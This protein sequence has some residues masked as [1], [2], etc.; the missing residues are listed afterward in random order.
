MNKNMKR[1][2]LNIAIAAVLLLLPACED[3]LEVEPLTKVPS[4]VFLSD[5]NGINT[6]LANLYVKMPMEDFMYNPGKFFNYHRDLG[7]NAFV[8]FGWST[9]FLTDE[10]NY[11]SGSGAGPVNDNYWA[12]GAVT[13]SGNNNISNGAYGSIRQVNQFLVDVE[14]ASIDENVRKRCISEGHFIRAY[15][16]FGLVKR[17][18][19]VPIIEVPQ[20]PGDDLFVP[21]STEKETFDFILRECDLAVEN[22]PA[23]TSVNDGVYRA[24][25]WAAYALKS[26]VALYAASVAKFSNKAPLTG[27]AVD[28][29]LVGGMTEADA[30]NYYSQC[31]SASAA[32]IDNSGKSLFRPNPATRTDAAKNFQDLFQ[33]PTGAMEEVIFMKAYIDGSTTRMQGHSYDV[34]FNPSQT[35]PSY[36]YYGRFNPTL[37]L[38]DLFEDY[39]DDG[40]GRSVPLETRTDGIEDE[41][42]ANPGT[43]LD[44]SKPYRLYNNPTEIFANKDARFFASIIT[45]G[46]VWKGKTMVI[47]GGLIRSDGTK[48]IYQNGSAVGLDGITYYTY[49][50]ASGPEYSG[51]AQLGN[52]E[53]GNFTS[54]GFNV[55]KYLRESMTTLTQFICTTPYIDFR[56][57]EIY[58]NYAEATVESG[59]GNPTLAAQYLND[60][61]RRAGHTDNIPATIDNI[62][63]ER[64]IELAFEGHRYWDLVR[65]RDSHLAFNKT[66]RK[67]LV[68][69]LDL[70]ENPPKYFFVRANNWPDNNAGGRT[71]ETK[72][73]Y[74][75]IPDVS[76]S[77][78]VQNPQY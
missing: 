76:T 31:I 65:R 9:S 30:N 19:G 34:Y 67:A 48:V 75:A 14:T 1:K 60:L 42:V 20:V 22:L 45:P 47:Q 21:R 24:T 35:A 8:D 78:L 6:L 39:S 72:S 27:E 70:R 15:M 2:V 41:Y 7:G 49:G 40:T 18:G 54:S 43:D 23:T 5:P 36:S 33:N 13:M 12:Y 38:V 57:A 63:K 29:K 3:W 56:L 73:Y 53:Q 11:S 37:N 69:V 17:Y 44:L 55:K 4:T 52:N 16:Y 25:K 26:R 68:P 50:G 64:R 62:L 66:T 58:L 10:S 46:S 28:L 77:G 59:Q 74:L 71:F 32:I 61:R 51:F